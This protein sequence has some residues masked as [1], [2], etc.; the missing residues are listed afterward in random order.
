[1]CFRSAMIRLDPDVH[2]PGTDRALAWVDP[3]DDPAIRPDG[4]DPRGVP[5]FRWPVR[6][7]EDEAPEL[8]E[9]WEMFA[10]GVRLP[11]SRAEWSTWPAVDLDWFRV[12]QAA[13]VR[14]L[15]RNQPSDGGRN[16]N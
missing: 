10:D 9:A 11:D 2:P 16:G 14:E 4:E 13:E 1:M 7:L 15:G 6:M 12:M 8:T 3:I 5:L